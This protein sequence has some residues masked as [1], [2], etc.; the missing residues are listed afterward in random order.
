MKS[1]SVAALAIAG[2]AAL[3]LAASAD[4]TEDEVTAAYQA[5]DAAFNSGHA[6]AV[7]AFYSLK[8]KLHTFN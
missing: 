6:K 7:A 3:P 2:T 4:S 8:L 5:W 1:F